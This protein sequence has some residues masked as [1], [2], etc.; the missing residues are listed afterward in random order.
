MPRQL[1]IRSDEAYALA[2]EQARARGIT[3]TEAVVDALRRTTPHSGSPE[4]PAPL[5]PAAF[6]P[7]QADRYRKLM[8]WSQRT[9]A[10]WDRDV[11][12]DHEWLYDPDTGLPK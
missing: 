11:S 5:A 7:E 1:N 9:A 12:A 2:H 10:K 8:D 4:R 3:V 6:T